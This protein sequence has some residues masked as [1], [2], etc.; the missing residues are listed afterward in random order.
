V[1]RIDP[2]GCRGFDLLPEFM[3]L[4]IANA[5]MQILNLRQPLSEKSDEDDIRNAGDSGITDQLGIQG[6]QPRKRC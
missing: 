6:K 2:F 5:S 4:A 1:A 3:P